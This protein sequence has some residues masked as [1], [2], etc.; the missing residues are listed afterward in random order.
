MVAKPFSPKKVMLFSTVS[1]D[2][3]KMTM[4]GGGGEGGQLSCYWNPAFSLT[5]QPSSLKGRGQFFSNFL[6][7]L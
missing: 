5:E 1:H 2:K 3:T 4:M 7:V 6:I